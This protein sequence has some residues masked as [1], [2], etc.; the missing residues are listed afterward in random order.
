MKKG[1]ILLVHFPFTD[2]LGNKLR[3]ALVLA[4]ES[5]DVILAF[6]TTTLKQRYD[7]DIA[8]KKSSYNRLKKDSVI[9][10]NK[11]VTLDKTLIVGKMGEL[12]INDIKEINKK[13]IQ[14]FD[15]SN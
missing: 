10:L 8:I 14:L 13:L 6:I 11:I 7:S 1:D 3:P 15:L 5:D 12:T 2:L 9:R 4:K